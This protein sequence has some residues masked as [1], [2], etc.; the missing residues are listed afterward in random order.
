[1]LRKNTETKKLG[2]RPNGT[3]GAIYEH[4]REGNGNSVSSAVLC[5]QSW[6]TVLRSGANRRQKGKHYRLM[7]TS[8]TNHSGMQQK[9]NKISVNLTSMKVGICALKSLRDSR[10]VNETKSKE[11]IELLCTNMNHKCSQLLEANTQKPRNPRFVIYIPEEVNAENAE[12]IITN[13]N[14]ELM[15]N[16]GEVVPKFTYRRKRNAM[17]MVIEFG[18]QKRQKILSTES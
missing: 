13:Y 14:L 9:H 2:Q 12:E 3:G 7:I 17:N 1:V 15:P 6:E 11:D 16:A 18:N 5:W 4:R 8:R 10:V